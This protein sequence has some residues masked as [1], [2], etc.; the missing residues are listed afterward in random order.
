MKLKTLIAAF[1]P[2]EDN[3]S[4]GEK[5]L[6]ASMGL[7]AMVSMLYISYYYLSPQQLPWFVGSM[8]ASC[9]LLFAIPHGPLS[10][11]WPFVAGHLLAGFIGISCAKL[12]SLPLLAA[13]IAVSLAIL[14]MYLLRCLHPPA[15]GTA[16]SM[17]LA[18]N[19][20]QQ[21]GYQY[22]STPLLTNIIILL[23]CALIINNI[24]PNRYYP[25]RLKTLLSPDE[26]K[27]NFQLQL[28][29]ED[30][31]EVLQQ[32]DMYID[33]SEE[34][35]DQIFSL[36]ATHIRQRRMGEISCRDIMTFPAISAQYDTEVETLWQLMGQYKIHCL[37]IVDNNNRVIGIVSIADFLNQIKVPTPDS[38]TL[39]T[40]LE[41]FIKRTPGQ[42]SN[43]PEYAGHIMTTPVLTVHQDQHILDL[44]LLIHQ[45][46]VHH[47]PVI[48]DDKHLIGMITPKDLIASLHSDAKNYGTLNHA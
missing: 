34:E 22:L 8:G 21:M 40:R 29:K 26:E 33:V 7:I 10:Q 14:G 47:I 28:A 2:A 18:N 25:S 42:H 11:P 9:L 3:T 5:I 16:L 12:I 20:I 27:P 31:K 17:A 6:S 1:A 32:Q 35:L 45:H 37:P 48:N 19:S 41:N 44:F 4:F 15:S 30:L 13:G 46:N 39:K 24:L 38:A 36:T 23:V 43:K